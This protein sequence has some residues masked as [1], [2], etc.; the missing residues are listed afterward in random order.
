MK[1]IGLITAMNEEFEQ[2][3]EIMENIEKVNIKGL[4]FYKGKIKNKNVVSVQCGI[5]KV[6]A[7][8]VTQLLIDC[9]DIESI[10]NLGAAGA[11]NPMLSIGDIVIGKKVIQHDFDITAF[12]HA[13]G[14]ITGVGD[15]LSSDFNLIDKMKKSIDNVNDR[16]YIIKTGIIASGDIF[17]TDIAMKDKIYAKFSADCVEMEAGAVAQ[18]CV[19]NRVPFL[20]LRSISDCPN[21]K[22]AMV[23]D[24]FVKLASKR[25]AKVIEEFLTE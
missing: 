11:L 18:V 6:N 15:Y 20:I 25:C 21:G 10:V 16:A 24:E 12:G 22:N 4:N 7:A 1:F 9:F 14:Y 19:L 5:G 13:K 23:F 17:C 2:I 3:A 8:R